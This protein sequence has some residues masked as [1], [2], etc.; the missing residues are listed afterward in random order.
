MLCDY[1]WFPVSHIFLSG[2]MLNDCGLILN[3]F[4]VNIDRA[5]AGIKKFIVIYIPSLSALS[6]F[7]KKMVEM[8]LVFHHHT[9]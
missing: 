9:P 5:G 7:L 8:L 4:S 3:V 1:L 6:I 2:L